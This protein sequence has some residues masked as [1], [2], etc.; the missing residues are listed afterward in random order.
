MNNFATDDNV[1]NLLQKDAEI[2]SLKT[3]LVHAR[4]VIQTLEEDKSSLESS[5]KAGQVQK[6]IFYDET[7]KIQNVQ[8]QE[9]VKLK[10]MLLFREQVSDKS[11]QHGS[12]FL[13]TLL[14]HSNQESLD[15]LNKSKNDQAQIQ[16]LKSEI[17]RLS[18]IEPIYENVKVS[19]VP[20]GEFVISAPKCFATFAS[21][22]YF[23]AFL[24]IFFFA[25]ISIHVCVCVFVVIHS[26][27]IFGRFFWPAAGE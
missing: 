9:I 22:N 26:L 24:I 23:G 3:E 25:L 7:D 10:S 5:I 2:N 12:V 15:Q 17:S 16:S 21:G 6:E 1:E 4:S 8:Q 11:D 19:S 13:T 20:H 18:R 14:A 27:L